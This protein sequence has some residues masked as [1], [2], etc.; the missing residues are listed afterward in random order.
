MPERSTALM[1]ALLPELVQ[2][3]VVLDPLQQR[4]QLRHSSLTGT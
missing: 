1:L 4:L 3:G 2:L